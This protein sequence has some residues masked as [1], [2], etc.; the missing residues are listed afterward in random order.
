MLVRLVPETREAV[1]AV[2]KDRKL[3]TNILLAAAKFRTIVDEYSY[4]HTH[5]IYTQ[6]RINRRC[7]SKEVVYYQCLEA[8]RM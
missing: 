7:L 5:Q 6:S 8:S 3:I 2:S 4:L 1:V